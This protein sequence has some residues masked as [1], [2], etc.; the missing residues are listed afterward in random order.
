MAML[1]MEGFESRTHTDYQLRLYDN[2]PSALVTGVGGRKH[3]FAILKNA[4]TFTPPA[5]LRGSDTNTWVL[6]FAIRKEA[7]ADLT[8]DGCF[9]SVSDS[10]GEQVSVVQVDSGD[11]NGTFKM[12]IRRGATV[13]A[14]SIAYAWGSNPTSWHVFQL[15]VLIDPTVGTYDLKHWDYFNNATTALTGTGANT[16]NQ[17]TAGGDRASFGIG[18]AGVNHRLDDVVIMDGTGGVN[19]DLT[20]NPIVVHGA[21]PSAEGNQ[22]DWTP[23]SGSNNAALIDDSGFAPLGTDKITASTVND[24]DLHA[25]LAFGLIAPSSTPT[26]LGVMPVIEGNM[27]NSGTRTVRARIRNG[28]SEA[29]GAVNMVFSST[30]KVAYHEVME[31]NPVT[32]AVWTLANLNADEFGVQLT[33]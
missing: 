28:G 2:A 3:G 6:Q 23:S 32:A 31:D 22:N 26:I 12:E 5:P 25:M 21:L 27:E 30:S 19:D 29:N 15:K 9:L 13:L 16:A 20:T 18:A 1:W 17:G 24:I 7:G 8:G 11:S 10:V 33:A 4:G 14:T